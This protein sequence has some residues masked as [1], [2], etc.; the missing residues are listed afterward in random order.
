MWIGIV[1]NKITSERWRGLLVEVKF[2]ST[3]IY[4][5]RDIAEN[6]INSGEFYKVR[7]DL[8]DVFSNQCP[9]KAEARRMFGNEEQR[10]VG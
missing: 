3:Q 1:S 5:I 2:Y 7:K 8:V 10:R 9:N 4:R 6:P